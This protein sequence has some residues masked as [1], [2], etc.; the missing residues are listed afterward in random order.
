MAKLEDNATVSAVL[1]EAVG[2]RAQGEGNWLRAQVDDERAGEG[3][4]GYLM[5]GGALKKSCAGGKAGMGWRAC[6]PQRRGIG[7]LC[8]RWLRLSL[9]FRRHLACAVHLLPIALSHPDKQPKKFVWGMH[10]A[11]QSRRWG[12]SRGQN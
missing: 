6:H 12:W 1:N 4:G 7:D 9:N 2:N 8:R 11:P 5:H 3:R 10:A